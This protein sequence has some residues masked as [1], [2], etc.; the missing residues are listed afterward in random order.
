[1]S[2]AIRSLCDVRIYTAT[3]LIF[4]GGGAVALKGREGEG[5]WSDTSFL[6]FSLY[7]SFAL[8]LPLSFHCVIL[9]SFLFTSISRCIK[10]V[11]HSDLSNKLGKERFCLLV[12]ITRN[13]L[14]AVT[15]VE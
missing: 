4:G 7:L 3:I 15:A 5:I 1:V 6:N 11:Y 13:L 9:I 10:K 14:H 8:F 2:H 12:L